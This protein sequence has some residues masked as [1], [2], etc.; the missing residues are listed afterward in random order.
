[1]AAKFPTT[2]SSIKEW[3]I[4]R[5]L[6]STQVG[7]YISEH[8]VLHCLHFVLIGVFFVKDYGVCNRLPMSDEWLEGVKV[9]IKDSD[10]KVLARIQH[11]KRRVDRG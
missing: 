9:L 6:K 4:P 11:G 5:R 1:M 2:S 8:S 7:K 10:V 3:R